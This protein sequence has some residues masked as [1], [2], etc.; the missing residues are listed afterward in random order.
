MICNQ[1]LQMIIM[2]LVFFYLRHYLLLKQHVEYEL[3]RNKLWRQFF[4]FLVLTTLLILEAV[5]QFLNL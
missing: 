4:A 5:Y 1:A 2:T 3:H